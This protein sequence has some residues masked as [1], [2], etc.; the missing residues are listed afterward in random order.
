MIFVA[1][2]E[3]LSLYVF[4]NEA[5]AIASCEGIDVEKGEW[6]FW[7]DL[8]HPL[9]PSFTTP[10]MR[11]LLSVTNGVYELV[12]AHTVQH[13]PLIEA[14]DEFLHFEGAK[15]LDSEAG[16]RSYLLSRAAG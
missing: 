5:E 12:A 2:P 3:S 6:L 15:P 1:E 8:G 7:N 13:A 14:L 16:V 11:G 10:N 9:E 4:S